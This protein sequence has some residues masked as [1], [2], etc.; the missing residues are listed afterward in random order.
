MDELIH[1]SARMRHVALLSAGGGMLLSVIGMYFAAIGMITP[2]MGALLQEG[3][4]VIAIL[5]ALQLN[6]AI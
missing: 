1:I 3:I 2:V 5:N 4:D 6:L